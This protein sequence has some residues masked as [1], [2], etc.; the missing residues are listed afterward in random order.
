MSLL[1]SRRV[2]LSLSI[3]NH[4]VPLVMSLVIQVARDAF[5]AS[6]LPGAAVTCEVVSHSAIGGCSKMA[7]VKLS[8]ELTGF[9]AGVPVAE[10]PRSFNHEVSLVMSPVMQRRVGGLSSPGLWPH[11]LFYFY[12][13]RGTAPWRNFLSFCWLGAVTGRRTFWMCMV[14]GRGCAFQ[15]EVFHPRGCGRARG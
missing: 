9:T 6:S 1:V 4:G 14:V 7:R 15:G 12:V 13:F 8:G 11:L 5:T 3:R 2:Y 10:Y